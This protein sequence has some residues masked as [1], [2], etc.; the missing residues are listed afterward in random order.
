M[1]TVGID[2]LLEPSLIE[3]VVCHSNHLLQSADVHASL[4]VRL[5]CCEHVCA[6]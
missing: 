6:V 5:V 2:V 3:F 4:L 1:T